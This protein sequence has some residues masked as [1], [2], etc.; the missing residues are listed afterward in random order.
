MRSST[1]RG[2]RKGSVRGWSR[3][4][5]KLSLWSSRAR[6]QLWKGP[7]GL[8]TPLGDAP[9]LSNQAGL[10]RARRCASLGRGVP[11]ASPS[12]LL[13]GKA[14]AVG[15]LTAL[16]SGCHEAAVRGGMVPSFAIRCPGSRSGVLRSSLRE[17]LQP[18][19][20]CRVPMRSRSSRA[21]CRGRKRL[22]L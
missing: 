8:R 18:L 7:R 4:S 19:Q 17:P 11:C 12:R 5:T 16:P 10:H 9:D 20:S 15:A 1:T 2:A 3:N 13:T 21:S 22:S 6:S 14:Q